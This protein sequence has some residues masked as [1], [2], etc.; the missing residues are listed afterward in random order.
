MSRPAENPFID[1]DAENPFSETHA[2]N[3][4]YDDDDNLETPTQS[5]SFTYPTTSTDQREEN[6]ARREVDIELRENRMKQFGRNNWPPFYPLIYLDIREEIPPEHRSMTLLAYRLWMFLVGVFAIN[7]VGCLLL[8]IQGDGFESL[9]AASGY[10]LIIPLSFLLWFRPLYNAL[11]KGHAFYFLVYLFFGGCHIAFSIYVF[12]GIPS[13]GGDG[14]IN[15]IRAFTSG[16]IASG[17][18]GIIST[19][20]WTIQGLGL[21]WVYLQVYRLYR[22][23]GLTIDAA[24]SEVTAHGFRAYF[25]RSSSI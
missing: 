14:L 22:Q 17:V 18:L 6:I 7:W 4:Q 1:E 16:K 10:L 2:L 23:K 5:N 11:M 8:L 15:T 13:T 24:K 25:S 19:V 21:A 3:K 12:I 9:A 20:G